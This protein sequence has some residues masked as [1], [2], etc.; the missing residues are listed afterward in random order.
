MTTADGKNN[1]VLVV[2]VLAGSVR[3]LYFL[4]YL[5]SACHGFHFADHVY[6]LEWAQ[7]ISGGD[8][9][10]QGPFE[11]GPLYAYLLA[12]AFL[13]GLPENAVLI[14]QLLS[15]VAVCVLVYVCG[16][17]LFDPA[18]ALLAAVIACCYGPLVYY[19]CM[20]MKSWLAPLLTMTAL[21]AGLRY[22]EAP[23]IGWLGLAGGAVGL[24]CLVRESYVLLMVPLVVWVWRQSPD[25]R[26]RWRFGH[27][28]VLAM[29]FLA[30]LAPSAI[31]NHLVAGELAVV[32]T[33]GG[34]V[35]YIAHG[36]QANGYWNPGPVRRTS[37]WAEHQAFH[38]EA[39]RRTGRRL[40]RTE[41]SRF[42]YAQAFAEIR[43]DPA[44]FLSL[45]LK[46]AVILGN[47]FEAPDSS[48]YQ[49]WREFIPVLMILPSFGWIVGAGLIGIGVC[50]GNW[51]HW[52]PLGFVAMYVLSVLLTYNFGRFRIGMVPVWVLFAAAGL[53][54]LASTWRRSPWSRRWKVIVATAF[55]IAV[56]MA[57][58]QIPP[59]YPNY[60]AQKEGFR[61]KVLEQAKS[62][63]KA[64]E[65]QKELDENP[66][67]ADVHSRLGREL[68]QLGRLNEAF[69]NHQAA[70]GL[71]PA[72]ASLHLNF[73]DDLLA[74][75]HQRRAIEYL[76]Q[77]KRIAPSL[78]GSVHYRLARA[79][80]ELG[81]T[82]RA[83]S[84]LRITLKTD[85][86]EVRTAYYLGVFLL[87]QP[88]REAR[89][90]A[91]SEALELANKVGQAA[92][93][94][95]PKHLH[96][97]AAALAEL[98]RYNEA[99]SAAQQ[100]EQ[101]ARAMGDDDLADRIHAHLQLYRKGGT[102]PLLGPRW[103]R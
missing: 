20:V 55:L 35:M 78:A 48:H 60:F 58:F 80:H 98:D 29:A 68:T 8:W 33:G 40:T 93:W 103:P 47:D 82:D 11:Q 1:P 17:R 15:G 23:R 63:K 65:L 85:F 28:A 72:D 13:A 91:A 16:R 90:R 43:K 36:P 56:T 53:T 70:I 99:I 5:R 21:Y 52:L 14:V 3:L 88:D 94:Q 44:R 45:T 49:V 86:K 51:R 102:A 2:I 27:V 95:D 92:K 67:Q 37:P 18:T 81:Q 89:K 61:A 69:Q 96:L 24:A 84:E 59:G 6:Y 77:A 10:G 12:L 22:A 34:E 73:A 87:A 30:M 4:L 26:L 57:A 62:R 71:K 9:L 66:G 75:G 7:R 32:T 31:R 46:R 50:L 39:E 19:E 100:A 101:L 76:L 41:S 79:Y 42:W 25:A 64:V 74:T 83:I 97:L 54:W 38:E